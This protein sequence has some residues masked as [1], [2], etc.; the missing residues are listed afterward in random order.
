M[1]GKSGPRIRMRVCSVLR[2][3]QASKILTT[4]LMKFLTWRSI[5]GVSHRQYTL[6]N[7]GRFSEPGTV[8]P[9]GI[10]RLMKCSVPFN[11]EKF[12]IFGRSS[13]RCHLFA[14]SSAN[15]IGHLLSHHF[16]ETSTAPAGVAPSSRLLKVSNIDGGRMVVHIQ[17]ARATVDGGEAIV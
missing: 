11:L 6:G 17:D 10:R 9:S 15:H 12:G 1:L 5:S 16:D 3:T 14:S 7:D 2:L 8:T 4:E 13:S